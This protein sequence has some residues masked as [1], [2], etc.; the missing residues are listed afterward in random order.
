MN[1]IDSAEQSGGREDYGSGRMCGDRGGKSPKKSRVG[2]ELIR[3]LAAE[4]DRIFTTDRARE[5]CSRVDMKESYLLEALHHL[6]QND[7]IISLRRGLYAISSALPGVNPA[8]EFEVAMYLV[9]PA[10][11]SHWSAMHYHG[12]TDQMPARVFVLTTSDSSVPRVRSQGHQE[13]GKG[14]PVAGCR[15][16][17]VSVRPER[18][19]GTNK[20]WLD[21]ARIT[22][23][24]PERTLI[25]GL[26]MPQYCGDFAEV[27]SAFQRS[28]DAIDVN[29]IV[30]YGLR[31]DKATARRL[32]WVLERAGIDDADL[33]ELKKVEVT[34]YQPLDPSGP[35]KGPCD[36]EWMI[37]ENLPGRIGA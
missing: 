37:Q 29:R 23:T 9:D 16:Q 34:R 5:L 18:F 3:E 10:A 17:F 36:G 1:N 32:G 28:A 19:F 33:T 35:R 21:D 20:V 30:S 6:R 24:D 8:H 22:V 2:V 27:L 14:Y 31:L 11:I 13:E 25:D 4:G 12:M 7:W 15:Y 26:T